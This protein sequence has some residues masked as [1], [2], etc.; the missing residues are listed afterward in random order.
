[1]TCQIFILGCLHSMIFQGWKFQKVGCEAAPGS[2]KVHWRSKKS[3]SLQQRWN[4]SDDILRD[5]RFCRGFHLFNFGNKLGPETWRTWALLSPR[6]DLLKFQT[7]ETGNKRHIPLHSVECHF[8]FGSK[9]AFAF[10]PHG[11]LCRCGIYIY[12]RG[13]ASQPWMTSY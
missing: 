3:A 11:C 6:W 1:M 12:G 10:T 5:D 7:S 8:F 4:P 13:P 2:F 9:P